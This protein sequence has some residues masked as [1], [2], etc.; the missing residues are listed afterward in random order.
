MDVGAWGVVLWS[1]GDA[2]HTV[3]I[4][5]MGSAY[6]RARCRENKGDSVLMPTNQECVDNLHQGTDH[7]CYCQS[8]GK[9]ALNS[10]TCTIGEEVIEEGRESEGPYSRS[11][12]V[13]YSRIL[14]FSYSRILVVS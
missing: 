13:S 12:V 14:V 6:R 11:L 5:A 1:C 8:I 9:V 7:G 2:H 3:P 4:Q 10:Y